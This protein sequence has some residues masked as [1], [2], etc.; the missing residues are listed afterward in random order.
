MSYDE[1]LQNA[2]DMTF[3]SF[4][5]VLESHRKHLYRFLDENGFLTRG[6]TLCTR[7]MSCV[8]AYQDPFLLDPKLDHSSFSHHDSYIMCRSCYDGCS[9][10]EK[11]GVKELWK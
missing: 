4:V 6:D 9:K 11:K 1:H 8:N 5:G 3:E 7:C 10:E 2:D